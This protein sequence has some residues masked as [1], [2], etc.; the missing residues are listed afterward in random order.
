MAIAPLVGATPGGV[1]VRSDETRKRLCGV[2]PLQ[3]LG[4]EGYTADV[5]RRVYATIAQRARDVI[6]VGHAAI[7]DAVF[8]RPA[9]RDAIERVAND[10]HVPFVGIWLEAPEPVLLARSEQ[11]ELDASDA[12]ATVIREQLA[13]GTGAIAWHPIDASR[14][15]DDVLRATV[16][17]LREHLTGG[18]VRLEPQTA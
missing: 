9:D 14:A 8:A 10:A 17:A 7:V 4:V 15:P 18:I 1:V 16:R 5:T 12:D 11:R 6:G 2:D 3:R 13:R